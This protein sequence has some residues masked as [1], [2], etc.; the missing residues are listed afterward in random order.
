LRE[1]VLRD[2]A[3]RAASDL[4][5]L[6]RARQDLRGTLVRH[7]YHLTVEEKRLVE[8][9]LRRTAE[10]SEEDLAHMLAGGLKGRTGRQP[11][12]PAAPSWR[13][14]GPARPTRPGS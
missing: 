4:Q 8:G 13:G 1:D 6:R 2:L 14:S 5:F 7:G 11:A 12:R 10:M 3:G 9:L